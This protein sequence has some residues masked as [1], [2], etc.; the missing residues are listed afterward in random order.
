M[1]FKRYMAM[2]VVREAFQITEHH[3]VTQSTT[4][5]CVYKITDLQNLDA[6]V[7]EFVSYEVPQVGGWVVQ[8]GHVAPYYCTDAT[9]RSNY[10]VP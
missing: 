9:F 5:A 7:G 3:R 8:A 4:D 6:G 10:L 2:P 1:K